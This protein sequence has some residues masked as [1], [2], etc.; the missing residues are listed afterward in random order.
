MG[1]RSRAY[2]RYESVGGVGGEVCGEVDQ[3]DEAEGAGGEEGCWAEKKR[4]E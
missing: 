3:G 2:G 4:Q 1:C